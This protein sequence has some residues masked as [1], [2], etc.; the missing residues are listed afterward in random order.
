MARLKLKFN[1]PDAR[2]PSPGEEELSVSKI[3]L[4][5]SAFQ[6][7]GIGRGHEKERKRFHVDLD[8]FMR[9]SKSIDL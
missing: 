3:S 7:C 5:E 4:E 2:I 9:L 8:G 1:F 6:Q